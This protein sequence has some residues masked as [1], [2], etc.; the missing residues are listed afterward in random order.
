MVQTMRSTHDASAVTGLNR[1]Y[2]ND[3]PFPGWVATATASGAMRL[4]IPCTMSGRWLNMDPSA[5]CNLFL[6]KDNPLPPAVFHRITAPQVRFHDSVQGY[7]RLDC[8]FRYRL[9]SRRTGLRRAN[10]TDRLRKDLTLTRWN[11]YQHPSD[12]AGQS[13]ATKFLPEHG[14]GRR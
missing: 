14:E 3:L 4:T 9:R 11:R 5:S 8:R 6:R 13:R 7:D 12:C 1:F 2:S 10:L